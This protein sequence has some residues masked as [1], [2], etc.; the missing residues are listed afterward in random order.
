MS[1]VFAVPAIAWG[2]F[3][4]WATAFPPPCG[5]SSA[6]AGLGVVECWVVDLPIG[7]FALAI[8]FFVKRGFPR[9]RKVCIVT[10]VVVVLLPIVASILLS[11][12]HCP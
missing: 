9:L 5:D 1:L 6:F 7:L 3:M 8:G 2:A 4:V 10:G 11:R 12:Y